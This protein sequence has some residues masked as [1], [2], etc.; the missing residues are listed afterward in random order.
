MHLDFSENVQKLGE[1]AFARCY[2]LLNINL[3]DKLR[4]IENECFSF[5]TSLKVFSIS[6][7]V[8]TCRATAFNGCS[9]L[10]QFVV[11]SGNNHFLAIDGILY[12]HK[13]TKIIRCP[14]NYKKDCV[15]IHGC[16]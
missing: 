3:N 10:S 16:Q 5:C 1:R 9:A 11:E 14:E 7:M 12:N 2:G 13:Q 8:D 15:V 6:P 4:I